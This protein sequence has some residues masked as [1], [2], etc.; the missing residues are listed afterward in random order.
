M[1]LQHCANCDGRHP[2]PLDRRCPF[3]AYEPP[4]PKRTTRRTRRSPSLSP[5]PPPKRGRGQPRTSRSPSLTP[6]PPP[7]PTKRGRGRPVGSKGKKKAP[8]R[9]QSPEA[10]FDAQ[11]Q[12]DS[13]HSSICVTPS[14]QPPPSTQPADPQVA[15]IQAIADQLAR[16]QQEARDY[17]A[18]AARDRE[19]D[20][21]EMFRRTAATQPAPGPSH[22]DVALTRPPP[23]ASQE[24]LRATASQP[25]PGPSQEDPSLSRYRQLLAAGGTTATQPAPSSTQGRAA[26]TAAH[27][28]D[29]LA[30]AAAN[31]PPGPDILPDGDESFS[32][33][34]PPQFAVPTH[35]IGEEQLRRA[36]LDPQL[37]QQMSDPAAALRADANS[38]QQAHLILRGAGMTDQAATGGL[39]QKPTDNPPLT[40]QWPH[41]KVWLAKTGHWAEYDDLTVEQFV[42][43]Y[44]QIVLPTIP[45]GP[46]TQIAR[47]HIC[48]LQQM[49]RDTSSAPWHLVRSTHKQ[50]LLMVEHKQ[51][52]WENAAA[53]DAIRAAQLLTAK[54]EAI[55]EKFFNLPAKSTKPGNKPQ[56]KEELK[57]C[58]SY[59]NSTCTHLKDHVIDGTRMLH[60]CAHCFTHGNH[61]HRHQESA[62]TKK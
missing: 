33:F 15:A 36:G 24:S 31:G 47:D 27:V 60:V 49:M 23:S 12:P 4:S 35:S 58:H 20:R 52:K 22:P 53:R 2:P 9:R 18:A 16:M 17:Q 46:A 44:I 39:S 56:P 26:P 50:I 42:Q 3:P 40:A 57:P 13:P 59:N 54:E 28:R 1:G 19:A 48:Y 14:G 25:T 21:Q 41:K 30:A 32:D 11:D 55:Q 8:P 43:G 10:S 51:L 45:Q 61:R 34:T 62:C 7:P 29:R 38:A 5:P 37:L 6:P